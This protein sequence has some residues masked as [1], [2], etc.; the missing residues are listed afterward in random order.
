MRYSDEQYADLLETHSS[1]RLLPEDVR[2]R[3]IDGI[4]RTIRAHG[5]SFEVEYVDSLIMAKLSTTED[6]EDT[7]DT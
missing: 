2:A 4:R 5:G 3:L 6:T 1:H 7:E